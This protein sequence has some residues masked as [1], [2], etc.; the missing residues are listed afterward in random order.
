MG[1]GPK[2]RQLPADIDPNQRKICK[3]CDTPK[4]LEEFPWS[5][6]KSGKLIFHSLCRKCFY[7]KY[8]KPYNQINMKEYQK[9]YHRTYSKKVSSPG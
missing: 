9:N 4:K 8:T 3:C 2:R 5:I 6:R 1:K 7:E